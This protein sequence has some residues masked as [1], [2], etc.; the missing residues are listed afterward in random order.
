[1]SAYEQVYNEALIP[2][3]KVY[4]ANKNTGGNK[5]LNVVYPIENGA[6][7]GYSYTN[8]TRQLTFEIGS[9]NSAWLPQQSYLEFDLVAS[10][11]TGG[12]ISGSVDALFSTV[13]VLSPQ[14]VCVL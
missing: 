10:G 13:R 4:I 7:Y 5:N 6:V 8:A 11:A 1:M 2:V 12:I 14:G 3:N 9:A